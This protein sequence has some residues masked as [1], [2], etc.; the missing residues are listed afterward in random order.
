MQLPQLELKSN[1]SPKWGAGH[2]LAQNS[3]NEIFEVLI[4]EPRSESMTSLISWAH[5]LERVGH[6]AVPIV[7]TVA[8]Q[9][10]TYVILKLTEGSILASLLNAPN[11]LSRYDILSVFYQLATALQ[12]LHKHGLTH[13]NLLPEHI[14]L[15]PNGEIQLRGWAPPPVQFEFELRRID[16]LKRFQ[17][18]FYRAL[19]GDF[20]PKYRGRRGTSLD[21]PTTEELKRQE[22]WSRWYRVESERGDGS[23]SGHKLL[24]F[25]QPAQ[26]AEELIESLHP[27]LDF[28][29]HDVLSQMDDEILERLQF[30]DL[31]SHRK[32]L[33]R[34]L[35]ELQ[36][37]IRNWLASH[38]EHAELCDHHINS[39]THL[40]KQGLGFQSHLEGLTG[41]SF[42]KSRSAS[43]R[44]LEAGEQFSHTSLYVAHRPKASSLSQAHLNLKSLSPEEPAPPSMCILGRDLEELS[45]SWQSQDL[46]DPFLDVL[47]LPSLPPLSEHLT[48]YNTNGSPYVSSPPSHGISSVHPLQAVRSSTSPIVTQPLMEGEPEA[49]QR[50]PADQSITAE[51]EGRAHEVP[52]SINREKSQAE[53]LLNQ[54]A[55]E[56]HHEEFVEEGETSEKNS[57][58][59]SILLPAQTYTAFT[60][61]YA[62]ITNIPS[63]ELTSFKVL[64]LSRQNF[65]VLLYGISALIFMWYVYSPETQE[66]N[67]SLAIAESLASAEAHTLLKSNTT[68]GQQET[69]PQNPASSTDKLE[70]SSVDTPAQ[71]DANSI[72]LGMAYISGGSGYD[73]LDQIAYSRVVNHCVYSPSISGK[74][75]SQG[76]CRN[77]IPKEDRSPKKF[78]V[79]SFFMDLFE[80]SRGDFAEYCDNGGFCLNREPLSPEERELPMVKVKMIEA[81]DYCLHMGKRLPTYHEWLFAARGGTQTLYPWGDAS[82]LENGAYRANYMSPRRKDRSEIDGSEGPHSITLSPTL[83]E[84]PFKIAHLSGNVSEWVL[85]H[86]RNQAWVAGGSWKSPLWNLR[87][88]FGR[89]EHQYEFI[90][91]DVGFRCAKSINH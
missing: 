59:L 65:F 91:D 44:G 8:H 42:E 61:L 53:E 31:I 19:V 77:R 54:P 63:S 58:F 16:D 75:L 50:P 69:S 55:Y 83:G 26:D 17:T 18:F 13:G 3:Q 25:D 85:R 28:Y 36:R 35:N 29:L 24:L 74:K 70:P 51:R 9:D 60:R 88:S 5:S 56:Y 30:R 12:R 15:L 20:P 34:D 73:G 27:F 84:S 78:K 14:L 45:E 57:R 40:Y 67:T 21:S 7:H 43:Q 48:P 39:L 10:Q 23:L 49:L 72:P 68:P 79:K 82:I 81:S 22:A 33:Q 4:A 87:V 90:A 86:K 46:I 6:A 32:K 80:V 76:Y 38:Q 66:T 89:Y 37:H 47:Q 2:F 52:Q 11:L 41:I 1:M 71:K 64:G 62:P